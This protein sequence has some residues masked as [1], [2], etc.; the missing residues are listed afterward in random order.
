MHALRSPTGPD[1]AH[2]VTDT[3]L[4]GALAAQFGFGAPWPELKR[5]ATLDRRDGP[6]TDVA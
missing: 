6:D 2:L 1:C 5:L 4:I 3:G